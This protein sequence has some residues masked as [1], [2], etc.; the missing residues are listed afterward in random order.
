M[1]LGRAG[2]GSASRPTLVS[3]SQELAQASPQ[4]SVVAATKGAKGKKA[5]QVFTELGD[6]C[7]PHVRIVNRPSRGYVFVMTRCNRLLC[8]KAGR[9]QPWWNCHFEEILRAGRHL[10]RGVEDEWPVK[11]P[12]LQGSTPLSLC[13][14]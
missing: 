11:N 8:R 13:G 10:G 4:E 12:A 5:P 9:D 2:S 6:G 3:S 14:G 1:I 7:R